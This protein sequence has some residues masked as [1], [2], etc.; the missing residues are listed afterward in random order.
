MCVWLQA[1]FYSEKEGLALLSKFAAFCSIISYGNESQRV[2]LQL[3]SFLTVQQD[4]WICENI[5]IS[6]YS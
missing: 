6:I 1:L 2:I 3:V 5:I 4:M